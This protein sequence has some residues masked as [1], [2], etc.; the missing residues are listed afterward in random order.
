VLAVLPW[1]WNGDVLWGYLATTLA[2]PLFVGLVAAH[3]SRSLRP[4]WWKALLTTLLLSVLAVTHYAHWLAGL[5]LLPLLSAIVQWRRGKG[6]AALVFLRDAA[7]A[8][9]SLL[10]IVPWLTR[11]LTWPRSLAAIAPWYT[12]EHRLPLDNLR[13]AADSLF[14][15]FQPHA[16]HLEA[17]SDLWLR[18]PGDVLSGLWLL[19][20]ALWLLGAVRQPHEIRQEGYVDDTT[21][22][23][24]SRYLGWAAALMAGLYLVL[25]KQ[26]TS[27]LQ[28]FNVNQRLVAAAA[29]VAM[30]ALPLRVLAPTP[31]ARRRV[32]VGTVLLT[33]VAAGVP[34]LAVQAQVIGTGELEHMREAYARLPKGAAVLTVR[35]RPY[36]AWLQTSAVARLGEWWDVLQ[37]GYT[38]EGFADPQLQPVRWKPSA[39]RPSPTRDDHADFGMHDHGRFYDFVA[40]YH[41]P[42]APSDP[43]AA[44][45]AALPEVFHRGRWRVF[46]VLQREPWPPLPPDPV[47]LSA[48]PTTAAGVLH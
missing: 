17:A 27:P 44:Q 35:D 16:A 41:D 6:I 32:W 48:V 40:V 20:V 11:T 19:G 28:L 29:I 45:L 8:L 46:Q 10:L 12:A 34:L 13:Q 31:R 4:R 22:R 33:V 14:D 3:L 2:L 30:C 18:R 24:G 23:D 21:S 15:R 26:I 38:P 7:L 9:P 43:F 5:L 39:R 42:F 37:G 47:E 36:S 1:A 25:P